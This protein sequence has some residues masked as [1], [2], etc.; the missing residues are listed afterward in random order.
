[1]PITH[2]LPSGTEKLPIPLQRLKI[3]A[4]GNLVHQSVDGPVRFE[5]SFRDIA[6]TAQFEERDGAAQLRL[7]GDLGNLPFSAEAR[8][9]RH[10]ILAIVKAANQVTGE[11][12]YVTEQG[13]L[14][15]RRAAMLEN[16]VTGPGL[17]TGVVSALHMINEYLDLVMMFRPVKAAR[18]A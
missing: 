7:V 17:I 10:N 2:H 9:A 13:R 6:F 12:F 18:R 14:L 8:I 16:P 5:F 11:S 3:D 4:D 15:L 1:M